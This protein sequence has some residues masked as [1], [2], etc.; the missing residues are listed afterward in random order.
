MNRNPYSRPVRELFRKLALLNGTLQHF[1]I[2][3]REAASAI[4]RDLQ[5]GRG[6]VWAAG[7]ALVIRD[8]TEWPSD[9]WARY[10]SA[11]AHARRGRQFL[12]VLRRLGHV[13]SGW[14]AS[15][16]FEEFE[17]TL[18]QQVARY[19]KRH[20]AAF[21][22]GIWRPSKRGTFTVGPRMSVEEIEQTVRSAFRGVD[23]LLPR[24]R[25]SIDAVR[26]A[27]V[28]NNRAMDL[29]GWLKV[30]SK[31]RDAHV[32]AAGL[33]S[34]DQLRR[35]STSECRLLV[36]SF[37]GQTTRVG[38]ELQM[39]AKAAGEVLERYAEYGNL[40]AKAMSQADS[41]PWQM[42]RGGRV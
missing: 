5:A 4:K 14:A 41:L 32:H 40:V 36:A 18:K 22:T 24:L 26:Q 23:D 13:S 29:V 20:P 19:F 17:R 2:H 34:D 31:V 3:L 39:T 15:Q 7:A 11:A 30:A 10:Y 1:D 25:N 12:T 9:R 33:I 38:Y 6:D 42:P 21:G 27:E 37:P 35:L 8:L 16:G 28:K